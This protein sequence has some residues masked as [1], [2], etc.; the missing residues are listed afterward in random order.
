M[1]KRSSPHRRGKGEKHV[2]HAFAHCAAQIQ[3][4]DGE[5]LAPARA[6]RAKHLV[7]WRPVPLPSFNRDGIQSS[8]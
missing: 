1:N 2:D 6:G 8:A 3:V 7:T 4:L 5:N